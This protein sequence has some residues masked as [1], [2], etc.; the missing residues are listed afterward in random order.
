MGADLERIL[1]QIALPRSD[2][3]PYRV[4]ATAGCVQLGT[5]DGVSELLARARQELSDRNHEQMRAQLRMMA[6]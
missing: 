1:S 4:S 5:A 6:H 3:S 2:V